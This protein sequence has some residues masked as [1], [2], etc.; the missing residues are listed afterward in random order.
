MKK[1]FLRLLLLLMMQMAFAQNNLSWQGYFSYNEIKDISA[2][3]NSVFA[4]SENALFSK[5]TSTNLIKTTNTVDGLSGQT[6]SA[7]YFSTQ[8]NKSIVGYEN[9]LLIVINE[10]DGSMLNVVDIINK[11]LPASLKKVNHFMEYEGIVYVSC[12]FGIVQFNLETMLFGDTYFIGDNGAEIV[13]S[14]TTIYNGFIYAATN[15]GIRRALITN[16][17]LNDFAQWEQVVS[18]NW[19]SVETFDKELIAVNSSG[20]I[21]KYN[22]NT[23]SFLGFITHLQPALDTR[24]NDLYLFVTTINSI[25]VYNKQLVLVHQ[26]NSNEFLG[27]SPTFSCAASINDIIYIGTKQNGMYTTAID[28]TTFEDITPMGPLRNNIFSLQATP[29]LFWVVY[30]DYSGDYNPYPL[31]EYGISK[32]SAAGWLNIPYDSV[33]EAKSI[34]RITINP[35]NENEVYASSFFSGLLKLLSISIFEK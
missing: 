14:Q 19:S 33:F 24:A 25:Y 30:G 5:N 18:G 7:L 10:S 6:I 29:N 4:A 35:N 11:Q 9:G 20:N 3:S 13:V 31:D 16:K 12:D 1:I 15:S 21:H 8:F 17:N 27:I 34:G 26:I 2:S 22:A 23:N 28:T 32:F